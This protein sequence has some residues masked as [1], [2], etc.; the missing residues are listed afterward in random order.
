[1]K[2]NGE[3]E[4]SRRPNFDSFMTP[5]SVIVIYWDSINADTF[6]NLFTLNTME[7]C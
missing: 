6:K 2:F 7:T 3:D 4:E 1:M 5:I